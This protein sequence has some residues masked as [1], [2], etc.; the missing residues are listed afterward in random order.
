MFVFQSKQEVKKFKSNSF[1]SERH[2]CCCFQLGVP[3]Q[4][5]FPLIHSIHLANDEVTHVVYSQFLKC[6]LNCSICILWCK[7]F[8]VAN[9]SPQLLFYACSC[10]DMILEVKAEV[11]LCEPLLGL[12]P[13][14]SLF[15]FIQAKTRFMIIKNNLNWLYEAQ[16][17]KY[18]SC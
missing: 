2:R 15:D 16:W 10:L 3:R 18:I 17:W 7:M 5:I 14:A 8:S 11:A 12:H 4:S 1:H 6:P 13:E 9:H